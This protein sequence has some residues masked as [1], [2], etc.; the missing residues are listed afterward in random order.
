MQIYASNETCAF[1][2]MDDIRE[3]DVAGR[4]RRHN[5]VTQIQKILFHSLLYWFLL[6][7]I[8]LIL[9]FLTVTLPPKISCISI[10]EMKWTQGKSDKAWEDLDLIW[11]MKH[12]PFWLK[13]FIPLINVLRWIYWKKEG[14]KQI[15]KGNLF[16]S[17]SF[18]LVFIYFG[19]NQPSQLVPWILISTLSLYWKRLS[20]VSSKLPH[21]II[22]W[23][24]KQLQHKMIMK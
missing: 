18:S 1:C 6:S 3:V 20:R 11:P 2:A 24:F 7:C 16:I 23:L 8:F 12:A 4:W 9:T 5:Q 21:R 14:N 15:K 19:V 17:L 10:C 22:L 13:S